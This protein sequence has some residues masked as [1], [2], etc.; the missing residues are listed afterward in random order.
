M[1]ICVFRTGRLMAKQRV[2]LECL[3][4]H[5]T[6][7]AES[8]AELVSRHVP[9][10][11]QLN[12][13]RSVLC[14]WILSVQKNYRPVKYHNWRHALNVTQTMFA[15]LR[16]GKMAGFISDQEVLGLMVACLSHDLDHRGT[17]N[18]FQSKTDSPLA[19]LYSTSTMEHHHFDQ[20][21]MI[22]NSEGNN[23]FQVL[24]PEDYRQVMDTVQQAIL[25]TDLEQYFKTKPQFLQVVR[26]GQP[27]WHEPHNK[28]LLMGMLM[29]AC[30]VS[31]ISKPWEI[32][33][34]VAKQVADEFFYQGDLER[35][36]L[37]AQ[38]SAMMDRERRD[39]LPKM[40]MEFINLICIPLYAGLSEAFPWMRPMYE[41]CLQNLKHWQELSD[42]VDI[43]LTWIDRDSIEEPV[44]T[45]RDISVNRI[46]LHGKITD[47][48]AS[49]PERT[50]S[51]KVQKPS[52][53]S[54]N[55]SPQSHNSTTMS[56]ASSDRRSSAPS[57][58]Q[59]AAL[60]RHRRFGRSCRRQEQ[61][62]RLCAI[63]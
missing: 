57:G 43:G 25:S 27:D 46:T 26:N 28:K 22:L 29:T 7:S 61:E 10:A 36:K 63:S 34:R 31:A 49:K 8:T 41:G 9:S 30:D 62:T 52:R 12:L 42:Q 35:T 38:P 48:P 19:M 1:C 40:Q 58:Q 53:S 55:V 11:L 51:V 37:N 23:I 14:R 5:A 56:M 60:G 21:V 3:S 47:S 45:S 24:K 39:E 50:L 18:A 20:C 6:A 16:T 15:L 2:A 54:G 33:H 59:P 13:Y 4:Y 44:E 17:N 32:Q